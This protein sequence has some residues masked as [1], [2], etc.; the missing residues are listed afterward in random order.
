[1]SA[2]DGHF[3]G[4]CA[5]GRRGS[6]G[7]R[8]SLLGNRDCLRD[9]N[10]PLR[11]LVESKI[12][13][14]SPKRVCMCDGIWDTNP[15]SCVEVKSWVY[16]QNASSQVQPKLELLVRCPGLYLFST[17]T[18]WQDLSYKARSVEKAIFTKDHLCTGC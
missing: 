8:I 18:Q 16:L 15:F 10:N 9:R 14:I 6:L 12:D 7:R 13:L 17:F 5:S 3:L 4:R 1:M 2:R 11:F